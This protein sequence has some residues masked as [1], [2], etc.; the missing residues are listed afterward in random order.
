MLSR[1]KYPIIDIP[2]AIDTLQKDLVF[3]ATSIAAELLVW[4]IPKEKFTTKTVSNRRWL[5][6]KPGLSRVLMSKRDQ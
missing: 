4:S 3:L 2:L 6:K 5:Q 1:E